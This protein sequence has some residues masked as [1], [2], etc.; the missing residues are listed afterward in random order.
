MKK[1]VLLLT[2]IFVFG[3]SAIGA[4]AS[5]AS[6]LGNEEKAV[7]KFL[8]VLDKNNGA[9][10]EIVSNFTPGLQKKVDEAAIQKLRSQIADNFGTLKEKKLVVLE[11]FDQGD[12]VTYLAGFSKTPIVKIVF[13]F[14][15]KGEKPLITDF[16]FTPV[17]VKKA[18]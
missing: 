5:N 3:L 1:I 8:S 16:A 7:D 12:R 15:V 4:A 14:D 9:Y 2:M 11:K 13:A 18:E 17:E 6:I 10:E